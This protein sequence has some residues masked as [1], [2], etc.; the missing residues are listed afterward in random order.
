MPDQSPIP[1]AL[2]AL[3]PAVAGLAENLADELMRQGAEAVVVTGSHAR[4]EANPYSDLDITAIGVGP[5][6]RFVQCGEVLVSFSWRTVSGEREALHD[7]ERLGAAVPAWRKVVIV[8]DPRGVAAQ[9]RQEA[10]A[11][12]WQPVAERCDAWV[13]EEVTGLSE[14]VHK[15]L[16][17][18]G[19]GRRSAAAVQRSLLVLKL[20]PAMA[21]HARL[22]HESEN[23]LW[24]LVAERMGSEWA[25][26]L[27]A[28]LGEEGEGLEESCAAALAL[29]TLAAREVARLLDEREATVVDAALG[30]I[31]R[32]P[33]SATM[34]RPAADAADRATDR[35]AARSA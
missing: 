29:F 14:E 20:A 27:G 26:A 17:N 22:L 8:R 35:P 7:P 25:R 12:D 4:G 1:A 30:L 18:L 2:A 16:G 6:T 10:Q 34:A 15:L 3:A 28:A 11:W 31:E 32:S 13:A 21:V 24:N 23:L 9:L 33:H 5:R 19:A